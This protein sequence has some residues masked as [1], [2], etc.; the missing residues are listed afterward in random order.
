MKTFTYNLD[1][2]SSIA[3]TVDKALQSHNRVTA[4]RLD[5]RLSDNF[6]SSVLASSIMTRFIESLKAKVAADLKHKQKAWQRH[7]T[8][9]LK[10]AWVREVGPINGKMHFHA[11]LLLNK[12]VYHSLG[13][14]NEK[15]GNLSAMIRQ[16]W[17]SALRLPF[18]EYQ[19]LVHFPRE[20]VVYMDTNHQ[21]FIQ[22]Q[23]LVLDKADYLAKEATKHYGDGQRSFGC[24]R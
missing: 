7:L 9:N 17:C 21:N 23:Q 12:D 10:Y 24:S 22:Q 13:D 2:Q 5:L 20:G 18:P 15:S 14:F 19:Q 4:I 8:C 11:L 1:Y 3:D 6:D 16:A